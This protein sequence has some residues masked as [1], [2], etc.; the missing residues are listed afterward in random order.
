MWIFQR[1][2]IFTLI[3][4]TQIF[5]LK[6]KI[7]IQESNIK[8]LRRGF[9]CQFLNQINYFLIVLSIIIHDIEQRENVFVLELTHYPDFSKHSLC[10][11]N[12]F[13]FMQF[14]YGNLFIIPSID[15]QGH[16]TIRTRSDYLL[17]VITFS[18]C[19]CSCSHHLSA[20]DFVL[21][22]PVY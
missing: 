7:W 9:F 18:H 4:K 16:L 2:K 14:F 11:N 17:H 19:E 5:Y 22:H 1:K 15:R 20:I 21:V 8:K 3:S 6:K 10:I 12:I 13:D